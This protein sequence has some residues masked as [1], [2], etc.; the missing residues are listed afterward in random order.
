[1]QSDIVYDVAVIGGG[2]SGLTVAIIAK[3]RGL[4]AVIIERSDRIGRKILVSGNGR[5]N[6]MGDGDI[7]SKYNTLDI[8]EIFS[9]VTIDNIKSFFYDL[10]V[11]LKLDNG[12]YYPYSDQS[13]TVLTAFKNKVDALN[14]DLKLSTNVLQIKDSQPFCLHTSNG[15]VFATNVVLA[16]GSSAHMGQDSLDLYKSYN[17]HVR[18]FKPALAPLIT[19]TAH[20]RG[21]KGVKIRAGAT[22]VLDNIPLATR[23]GDILFKDNGVSGSL[24]LE[25]SSILVRHAHSNAEIYI[26]FMP[27]IDG[28]ELDLALKIALN[29]LF[30]KEIVANIL[31]RAKNP[32]EIKK[33]IKKYPIKIT[34]IASSDL[35]QVMSGGLLLN[36]FNLS[37]LE[38]K[39]QSKL[40]A[41]GEVLDVDGE[42]G[43]YNLMWAWASGI[44]V[45]NA[46]SR[47]M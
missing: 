14:I 39:L 40:Y 17:H 31:K 33:L 45:G 34:G 25:L 35:A 23:V 42:C 15:C 2:A 38:S 27:G 6:L 29:G 46:L 3:Q 32:S 43:G 7:I 4:K 22:I 36:E 24:A 12:R 19:D 44:V 9:V 16:T 5:C 28:D 11:Y 37:T 41:V 1:V 18:P 21:L 26:D 20:I 10:G 8:K 47:Q 13:S 30:H